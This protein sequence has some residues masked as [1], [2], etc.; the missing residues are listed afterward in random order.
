ISG[1]TS[2]LTGNTTVSGSDAIG[3]NKA[4]ST[5]RS[6]PNRVGIAIGLVVVIRCPGG[7]PRI[8]GEGRASVGDVVVGQHTRRRVQRSGNVIR[9]ARYRLTRIT[10]VTRRHVVRKQESSATTG[11]QWNRICFAIGLAV[12]IRRP[13]GVA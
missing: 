13:G 11:G 9:S 1:W 6:Q 3:G 12:R 5:A 7:R 8:D 2:I 10:A 4:A